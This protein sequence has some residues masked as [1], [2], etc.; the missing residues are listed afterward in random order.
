MRIFSKR[1]FVLTPR[2]KA[3]PYM[4]TDFLNARIVITE[5][6]KS[7]TEHCDQNPNSLAKF[8]YDLFIDYLSLSVS[9]RQY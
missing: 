6:I 3:C 7:K 5:V 1:L 9:I 2:G 8:W 4:G